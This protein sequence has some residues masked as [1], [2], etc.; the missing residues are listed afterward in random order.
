[1]VRTYGL[2][3]ARNERTPVERRG[4]EDGGVEI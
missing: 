4:K 1:M 3:L 2:E